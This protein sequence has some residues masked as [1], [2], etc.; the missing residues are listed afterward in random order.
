MQPASIEAFA[1]I[2]G[3]TLPSGFRIET[4]L[5]ANQEHNRDVSIYLAQGDS[6][7]DALLKVRKDHDRVLEVLLTQTFQ[8]FATGA[9]AQSMPGADT[10]GQRRRGLPAAGA[11]RG[12]PSIGEH[13]ARTQ[14]TPSREAPQRPA[15]R[16]TGTRVT[17]REPVAIR[18]ASDAPP[19]AAPERARTAV[20]AAAAAAPN[21]TA[22]PPSEV[23]RASA[24]AA[25]DPHSLAAAAA[26]REPARAAAAAGDVQ[27]RPPTSRE[28]SRPVATSR[29]Q[30]PPAV[31]AKEAAGGAVEP[32]RK[33]PAAPASEGAIAPLRKGPATVERAPSDRPPQK[34]YTKAD[35]DR[36]YNRY[37]RKLERQGRASE[38]LSR[39]AWDA[40]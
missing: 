21:R 3:V 22:P 25:N 27:N 13:E 40:Q 26:A 15:A 39:E 28:P 23:S 16:P 34:Q 36:R 17:G 29:E 10:L 8:I 37:K 18:P 14:S 1:R 30:P 38:L 4:V 11:P 35:N 2:P 32:I 5:A 9:A 24:A 6:I 20:A 31:P 12:P 33:G 7:D 19:V